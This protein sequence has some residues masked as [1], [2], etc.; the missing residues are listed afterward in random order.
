MK[1]KIV[2]IMNGYPRVGKDTFVDYCVEHLENLELEAT[3]F[4]TI[5]TP[6][7]I[8]TELGW[9]GHKNTASRVML[10][11]L[12]DWYSKHFNGPFLEI[13][14]RVLDNGVYSFLFVM[15]REPDEIQK[16][17]NFCEMLPTKVRCLSVLVSNRELEI[18]DSLSHSDK[19]ILNMT[20]DVEITN[21]S[22]LENLE[23]DAKEFAKELVVRL[24]SF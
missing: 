18:D 9:D 4:S 13:V 5:R 8:A 24:K 15:I 2:V 6:K 10:S 11:E 19:N 1:K 7:H 22:T 20:Y 14:K 21:E 16:V 23:V 12:K 17:K 3:K